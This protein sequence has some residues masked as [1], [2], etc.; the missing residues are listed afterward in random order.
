M[1]YIYCFKP[2][3]D[4]KAKILI[5]GSMPGE[6][7][8]LANQYYAHPRNAFWRIMAELLKFDPAVSYEEK[9]QALHATHIALWDV[10]QSCK[11]KGSLDTMIETRTQTTND[12]Q[13]FLH[14]H[15]KITH[16]FFNGSKAEACFKQFVQKKLD[17]ES[18][19]LAKLPSTSPAHATI[20]FDHKR[21]IW[22]NTLKP[23]LC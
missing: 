6:A 9:I 14:T 15:N 16:I 5:L 3:A 10:L 12:F 19:K 2:I 20:S 11:R 18:I 17:L 8:L 13:S 4:S 21:E 22:L 7:S 1:A 23:S